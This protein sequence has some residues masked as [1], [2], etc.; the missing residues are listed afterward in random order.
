[1]TT[2]ERSKLPATEDM[3][4]LHFFDMKDMCSDK[5][6]N[7]SFEETLIVHKDWDINNS[8]FEQSLFLNAS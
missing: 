3:Y 4:E 1:M 8:K 5:H 6:L 7:P 2:E